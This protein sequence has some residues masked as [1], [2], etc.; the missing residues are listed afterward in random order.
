MVA[1]EEAR[2]RAL[3]HRML[4]VSLAAAPAACGTSSPKSTAAG[5]EAGTDATTGQNGEDSGGSSTTDGPAGDSPGGD[6]ASP[7]DE[8]AGTD[9]TIGPTNDDGGEPCDATPEP[10]DAGDGSGCDTFVLLA[11]GLPPDAATENCY[12]SLSECP[13]LCGRSVPCRISECDDAG[14][15][16]SGPLSVE[17]GTFKIGCGGVGRRPG[18]LVEAAQGPQRDC[19]GAWLAEAAHLEAASVY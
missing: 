5:S 10:L 14:V 15:V 8:D 4:L 19:A 16:A 9:A 7:G 17:C 2:L 6:D 12:L 18:G 1:R 11:C 13:L 3:F